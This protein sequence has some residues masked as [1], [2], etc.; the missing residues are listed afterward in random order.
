MQ[1]VFYLAVA[2]PLSI[3]WR[4]R[5]FEPVERWLAEERRPTE[6]EREIALRQ[7]M[8]SAVNSATF[9][10]LAAILFALLNVDQSVATIIAIVV[11]V[12]LGG[13][14]TCALVYLLVERGCRPVTARAL[15]AGPPGRPV[16]PGVGGRLTMAWMLGLPASRSC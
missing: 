10:G 3:A 9:W 16:T 8:D 15:A 14:T 2:F 6:A 1:A 13:A 4:R 11:T 7:P 12:I 5:Q